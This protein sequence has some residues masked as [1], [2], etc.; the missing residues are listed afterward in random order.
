MPFI[1]EELWH[2]VGYGAEADSI[3][4]APWPAAAGADLL[5]QWGVDGEVVSY[6]D[7]KHE[8][9]R[10]GRNLRSDFNIAPT[11]KIAY[12]VKP[13]SAAAAARLRADQ[14]SVATLLKAETV[15]VDPDLAPPRAMPSGVC[16]LGTLYMPVEGL[17]DVAAER[18]RLSDQL[19]K[20]AGELAHVKGKLANEGFVGKA[21]PEVVE[22]QRAKQ[23]ELTE[24]SEK[25]R[26]LLEGL[27]G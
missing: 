5:R 25:V 7:E 4:T 6:V 22:R 12:L 1:T 27:G 16:K 13:H 23:A 8:L 21:P 24:H 3:M 14:A 17:L 20:I 10:I 2:T 19:A 26:R 18:Q 15:Q 11:K 9:V